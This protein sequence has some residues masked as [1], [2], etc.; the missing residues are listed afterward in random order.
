MLGICGN[1]KAV[2]ILSGGM[3]SA[4]LLYHLRDEEYE[5]KALSINY[6]QRH[7]RELNAA[8]SICEI[9]E[10]ELRIVDLSG[11]AELFGTNSLTDHSKDVPEGPY[12]SG[13]IQ[14]TTVP[15]R[16]MI[17][18]AIAV[19]WALSIKYDAVALGIHDGPHTNYADCKLPFAEAMHAVAQTCDERKIE[20]LSP[21]VTWRKADI[22]RRAVELGVPLDV[23]WSCYQGGD[24][25]CGRCGTCVDRR[26]AFEACGLVDPVQYAA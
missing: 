8:R 14:L 1:R 24:V 10:C 17:L 21:F 15:N 19:G 6:G 23:T 25:H 22:A 11:L 16:N 20:V 13:T 3:D 4:T 12:S 7:S 5:T 26:E 2:V 18:A 9:A